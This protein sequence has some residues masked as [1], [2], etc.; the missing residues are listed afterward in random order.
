MAKREGGGMSFHLDRYPRIGDVEKRPR[1]TSAR[2]P[3]GVMGKFRVTIQVDIFRGD[4][5]V[6]WR[7]LKHKRIVTI[8]DG[9]IGDNKLPVKEAP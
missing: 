5:D 7:C 3:C 8:P 1:N 9:D 6:G 2:C 4:D